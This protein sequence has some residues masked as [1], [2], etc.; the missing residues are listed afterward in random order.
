MALEW[1]LDV[2]GK[3]LL[4]VGGDISQDAALVHHNL[5]HTLHHGAEHLLLQG[6]LGQAHQLINWHCCAVH[7][8]CLSVIRG[9]SLPRSTKEQQCAQD[10]TDLRRREAPATSDTGHSHRTQM[11]Y[12]GPV[13]S[14]SCSTAHMFGA[15]EFIKRC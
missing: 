3:V 15:H 12:D 11:D 2:V 14:E 7:V 6:W 5:A 9:S 1:P 4:A 10:K 8:W 13:E